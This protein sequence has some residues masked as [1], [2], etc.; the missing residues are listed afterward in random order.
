MANSKSLQ[1][2]EDILSKYLNFEKTPKKDSLWLKNM[3]MLCCKLNNPQNFYKSVH[4]AGSKGKGSVSSFLASILSEANYETGLFTSPHVSDISERVR[5]PYSAFNENVYKNALAIFCENQNFID[6]LEENGGNKATWFELFTIYSFL[7]FKEAHVDWAVF[8]VGLGGRLDSTNVIIPQVCLITPIEL[9]HTEFLGNTIEEIAYEKAGIIKTGIPVF[10]ARQADSVCEVLK[11]RAQEVG[12]P[13]IFV[14]DVESASSSEFSLLCN[15]IDLLSMNLKGRIQKENAKLACLAV[16]SILP[17]IDN[18]SVL[19]GIKKA[20]IPCRFEVK[21]IN[22]GDKCLTL[23]LDGCHTP[24]SLSLCL[25]TFQEE[26]GSAHELLFACAADKAVNEM[27]QIIYNS[28][29]NFSQIYVTEPGGIKQG[30]FSKSTQAFKTYFNENLQLNKNTSQQIH[31]AI[32]T[33]TAHGKVLL[34]VGSFYL[35]A[36]VLKILQE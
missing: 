23:V 33:A 28:D 15:E 19:D 4:V 18:K 1:K 11:N 20:T 21:T 22:V 27:A 6:S 9:E 2:L 14:D 7:C 36:E 5:G 31:S 30:D 25:K 12:S 32:G 13:L 10:S 24:N 16:K 29:C 8:E 3:E 17:H 34:C 35:C 26:F